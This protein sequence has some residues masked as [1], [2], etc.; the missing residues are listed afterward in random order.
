M[1]NIKVIFRAPTIN[2]EVKEVW[3]VLNEYSWYKE[4]NYSPKIPEHPK[5]NELI[6]IS[7]KNNGLKNKHKKQIKD[8]VEEIYDKKYYEK[9]FE[10]LEKSKKEIERVLPKFIEYN[11]EW[12][13]KIP[14]KYEIVPILYGPGG[15]YEPHKG[16][17]YI[18][19][20]INNKRQNKKKSEYSLSS[21]LIHE[22]VHIGIQHLIQ[23]FKI[24]HNEK[25]RIVDLF[26]CK[27]LKI[28]NYKMQKRGNKKVDKFI[29]SNNF[30]L[31]VA[32]KEYVKKYP[33]K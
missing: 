30:N 33:R 25:E 31:P 2:E 14:K 5:I 11:K 15:S 13:F 21:V 24:T 17:V 9:C 8:V 7:L 29:L 23:K 3:K 12:K 22:M 4:N 28:K 20:R 1:K 18:V 10:I 6:G 26:C 16:I 32:L 19:M 27:S